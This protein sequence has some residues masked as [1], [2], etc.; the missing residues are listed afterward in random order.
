M[1]TPSLGNQHPIITSRRNYM[2][3][4]VQ[5]S[6]NL[7]NKTSALSNISPPF[8]YISPNLNPSSKGKKI[9]R[10]FSANSGT[11]GNSEKLN[12]PRN[13]GR[14]ILP[15][16]FSYVDMNAA[17]H[18]DQLQR[19]Q[20]NHLRSPTPQALRPLSSSGQHRIIDAQFDEIN[21]T[22]N[23][24]LRPQTS[25]V[26]SGAL[27]VNNKKYQ[28]TRLLVNSGTHYIN[29]NSHKPPKPQNSAKGLAMTK[30][31][32]I[33]R[34][35]SAAMKD[36]TDNKP[37]NRQ[38]NETRI[39]NKEN[40]NVNQKDPLMK[41]ADKVF[42]DFVKQNFQ[43]G[44]K[45][46]KK[47]KTNH[48]NNQ[49]NPKTTLQDERTVV[50]PSAPITN[51]N[52]NKPPLTA[53]NLLQ[54]KND[55]VVSRGQKLE[56]AIRQNKTYENQFQVIQAP[57]YRTQSQA[58][59]IPTQKQADLTADN[60]SKPISGRNAD[61]GGVLLQKFLQKRPSIHD[62][63][64]GQKLGEG[65]YAIVRQCRHKVTNNKIAMKI[66]DKLRLN[67]PVKKRS[68]SREINLLQRL[69]HP[70]IVKFYESIDTNKTINLVMEHVK[71]KSL[72]SY[73][74]ERKY[75]RIEEKEAKQIFKQIVEGVNYLH[76]QNIAHRDL[77]PDNILIDDKVSGSFFSHDYQVKII[78]FG[79]SISM[80]V[81]KKLKTFCGTPSFMS[82][83]IVSKRDYCGKQ[84]D[85]WA[86]GVILYSMVFGRTPFRAE[87]ERELYRKIAK[88][89][90]YFPDEVYAKQEEFKEIKVSAQLK[91]LF[92]RIFVVNGDKRPSC[93]EILK[94]EWFKQ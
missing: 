9:I 34:I 8:Q 59:I 68:V 29:E 7:L 58:N 50:A 19:Y 60:I 32:N 11:N 82:P 54:D 41:Q 30:L 56:K 45:V 14:K 87:N 70:N 53:F 81:D 67:D 79:F 55:K 36:P 89:S 33:K 51:S 92:K 62:Y 66:Y 38:L 6:S 61:E 2:I 25:K 63:E 75:R 65:A 44:E 91:G 27:G 40:I 5:D 86:L 43:L 15:T 12:H 28:T 80:Q 23:N 49:S 1:K 20:N 42:Q 46:V 13:S 18:E 52:A 24:I 93:D 88:G 64:L 76:K 73:L 10:D 83:E 69:D 4:N 3:F 72:Y 35:V 57:I 74:K 22:T 71:G 47:Q 85:I 48:Q 16:N 94:D 31:Q 37:I 77:K 78:D 26:T 21:V 17:L 39:G 84:S 90:F